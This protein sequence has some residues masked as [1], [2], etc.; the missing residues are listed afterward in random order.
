[1]QQVVI[2]KAGSYDQLQVVDKPDLELKAGEVLIQCRACGVNFADC[3][4]RM[5]V[6]TSAKVYKGWPITPGFEVAGEV[7]A[8]GEGVE[9]YQP[10][11]RV[12]ACTRFDGYSSQLSIPEAF[13][14][15]L[16]AEMSFEQG[17]SIPTIFLTAYF[18][19]IERANVRSGE[20]ILV[21]S[22]AGGVGSALVQLAKI[23]GCHVTGVV[24]SSHKV[25][26]VLKLGADAV[27]DKSTESLWGRAEAISPE[28]Y[29]IVLDA[30]GAETLAESYSHMA[31]GGRL[32]VYGFHTML[33]KGRG[34]LN[35]PKAAWD[36]LRTPRFNPLNMTSENHSVLAFNLSFLFDKTNMFSEIMT[37]VLAWFQEGRLQLPPISSFPM[38]KVQE[39]HRALESGQ[40]VGKIILLPD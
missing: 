32:V 22:A 29:D 1:M 7:L 19:L 16:P 21:H 30:N 35:W 9:N 25:D 15:P 4:V 38:S 8:V 40:T 39:A 18:G 14:V 17:A 23:K 36:Y 10:G 37:E 28:G 3:C 2:E 5:G 27:I 31:P 12:I 20:R 34:R 11:D 33:S 24:G 13:V 6:Y 26:T